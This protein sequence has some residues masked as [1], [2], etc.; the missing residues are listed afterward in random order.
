LEGKSKN[1]GIVTTWFERGAGYVSKSFAEALQQ[2]GYS[3]FIYARGGEKFAKGNESWDY[4]N[5]TWNSFLKSPIPTDINKKQFERWI[6]ENDLDVVVFNEQQYWQPVLWAKKLGISVVAYVDY[7]TDETIDF[8][9]LFDALI[10]NTKQHRKAMSSFPCATY[11][12]W[13]TDLQLF[14]PAKRSSR[15]AKKDRVVFFHSAGMSPFRKG[16][17]ILIRSLQILHNNEHFSFSVFIH[18]QVDLKTTF[19]ELRSE[20]VKLIQDQVIEVVEK[21]I[22]APGLYNE[23]DIY[24]YP[25]RL[26]GI[27]LTLAE[28]AACGLPVI[29]TNFG[30]MNE[31]LVPNCGWPLQVKNQYKRKDNYYWPMSEV[32]PHHLADTLVKAAA[33]YEP[34]MHSKVR[35]YAEQNFNFRSN[36]A[37]LGTI[38]GNVENQAKEAAVLARAITA[39]EKRKYSIWMSLPPAFKSCYSCFYTAYK[40]MRVK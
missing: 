5:V 35:K 34:T 13:G 18:S 3:T 25:S 32:C 37:A 29:T 11:V 23:G 40:R 30:P 4:E 22:P 16:T 21:T 39:I 20:I 9:S 6:L 10:C 33:E 38:I 1:I 15:K 14:K 26:E 36:F 2:N 17:D 31:F 19:P 28:A 12:P 27:G 24:V 8:F 7:Y